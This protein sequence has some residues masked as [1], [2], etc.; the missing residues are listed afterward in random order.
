[1]KKKLSLFLA[2]LLSLNLLSGCTKEETPTTDLPDV[3]L[4]TDFRVEPCGLA[5]NL[6]KTWLDKDN[7]NLI[8]SSFVELEADIYG[9]IEY[10]FAP[11]E[12]MEA[13]NDPE[14]V[15]PIEELMTPLMEFLVVRNE[16]VEAN[17]VK[18]ELGRYKNVETLPAQEGFQ[19]YFLT[20]Y[21]GDLSVL[22]KGAKTTYDALVADL[23]LVLE[24]IETFLP[25]EA[26]V[27]ERLEAD[28]QYLNFIST[29]LEGNAV[30]S[31]MFYD[32]DMT[33]VNFWASYCYPDIN[34]L[35]TLQTFYKDLQKKHPNVNFVQVIIDT[36]NA[37]AEAVIAKAYNEA[38][39]TFTGVMPDPTLS[40]WIIDNLKGLPTTVFVD[41]T[42]KTFSLKVEGIQDAA[43]YMETTETMLKTANQ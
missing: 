14:S 8:P 29:D 6:P 3:P 37:D 18:E 15:T 10:K 41:K 11:D 35:E 38:G 22:S 34:E 40:Q 33:V 26:A 28:K 20:D 21:A 5:Y 16:N 27:A 25:D 17:A 30:S 39:V 31:T 19:F 24:T 32:Y 4:Q 36:P 43:Y 12:S 23:P 1:M 7:V 42:G 13:L 9:K 2:L